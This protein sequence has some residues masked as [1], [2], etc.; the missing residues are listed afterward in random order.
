MELL[1]CSNKEKSKLIDY[2]RDT[3]VSWIANK[4]GSKYNVR[5]GLVSSISELGNMQ[6]LWSSL[7]GVQCNEVFKSDKFRVRDAFKV[8]NDP[9]C[10]DVE[11]LKTV[12]KY[13]HDIH[14]ISMLITV[15]LEDNGEYRIFDGNKRA[16]AYYETMK[17]QQNPKI[18]LKIFLLQTK[19]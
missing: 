12:Q 6:T 19:N 3:P 8:L 2:L 5:K 11:S 13:I 4:I 1:D 18:R 16:V 17:A 7:G 15:I 14:D 9:A 10:A